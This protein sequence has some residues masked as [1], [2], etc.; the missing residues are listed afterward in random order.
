MISSEL[1]EVPEVDAADYSRHNCLFFGKMAEFANLPR[2][3]TRP[4][5]TRTE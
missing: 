4:H 2:S 5:A 1:S 3:L